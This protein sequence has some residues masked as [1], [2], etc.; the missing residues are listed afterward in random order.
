[1]GTGKPIVFVYVEGED[2]VKLFMNEFAKK[3][4]GPMSTYEAEAKKYLAKFKGPKKI[5]KEDENP[6]YPV[7]T[8]LYT[9]WGYDQTNVDFYVVIQS[10]KSTLWINEISGK[11]GDATGPDSANVSAGKVDPK[12]MKFNSKTIQ[13]RASNP[14]IEGRYG[15][16]KDNGKS[17]YSSWGH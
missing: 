15:L 12:D 5:S 10:N 11:M 4:D 1:M 17:H 16:Y 6:E 3:A 8:I 2:I 13:T 14:K 7:G 9:S